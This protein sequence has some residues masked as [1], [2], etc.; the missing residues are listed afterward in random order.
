Y[1]AR[2]VEDP[3]LWRD[4]VEVDLE[5]VVEAGI[6]K[7]LRR[8]DQLD[9]GARRAD[10][11]EPETGDLGFRLIRDDARR[12]GLLERQRPLVDERALVGPGRRIDDLR[13]DG[14]RRQREDQ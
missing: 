7:R 8:H 10:R 14:E 9:Q 13:G 11:Q 1:R 4:L 3:D 5:A 12:I 6:A 2:S